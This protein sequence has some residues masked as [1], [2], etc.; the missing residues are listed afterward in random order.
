MCSAYNSLCLL[1]FNCNY[2]SNHLQVWLARLCFF[3]VQVRHKNV[4]C[5]ATAYINMQ[6]VVTLWDLMEDLWLGTSEHLLYGL[7]VLGLEKGWWCSFLCSSQWWKMIYSWGWICWPCTLAEDVSVL[8]PAETERTESIGT[9]SSGSRTQFD[10][11]THRWSPC[12][13]PLHGP[14]GPW[15]TFWGRRG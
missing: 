12:P 3:L 1:L 6:N 15:G 9:H 10:T 8:L 4:I 11:D 13:W 5:I 7:L 2:I 14:S